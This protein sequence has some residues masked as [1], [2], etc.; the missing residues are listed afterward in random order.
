MYSAN[1]FSIMNLES[2]SIGV[3]LGATLLSVTAMATKPCIPADP[4]IEAQVE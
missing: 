1:I 2:K 3:C 4:K